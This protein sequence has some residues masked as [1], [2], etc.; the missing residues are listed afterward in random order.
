MTA[1]KKKSAVTEIE[2]I[3]ANTENL[4]AEGIETAKADNQSP[5][6]KDAPEVEKKAPKRNVSRLRVL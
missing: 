3:A 1:R 4:T 5:S 6:A 2:N